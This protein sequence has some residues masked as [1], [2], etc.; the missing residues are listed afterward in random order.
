[1]MSAYECFKEYIALKNHFTQSSYDYFKYNG[2]SR[3]TVDT[4]EKRND[5]LF[6]MKM[7]KHSDAFNYMLA[8]LLDDEKAWIKDIAYSP[9]AEQIY[10][11]WMKRSQSL[12]YVFSN[13]L[14]KLDSDFNSNFKV[15]D[16]SHPLLLKLYLRRE[17]SLETLI[18]LVDLVGCV[19]YWSKKMEYDPNWD[20]VSIKIQKY[21]PFLKYDREKY[22]KIVLDFFSEIG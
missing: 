8:N 10:Q 11:D 20:N 19:K 2:K 16:N 14:A 6:F 18:I 3:V 13:E 12:T 21:R 1:M 4:F 5:K 9:K 7:A 17:I 15:K 22:K